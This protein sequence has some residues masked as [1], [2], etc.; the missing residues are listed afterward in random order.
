[1]TGVQTCALPIS[2]SSEIAIRYATQNLLAELPDKL[3]WVDGS[4]LSRFNLF[5]P[6]TIVKL[7][8]KIYSEVPRERLFTLLAKGGKSGTIKNWYKAEPIFIYG[9]T[10]TLSNNHCLSGFLITK[11][12]KTFIFSMMSNNFIASSTELRKQME[13]IFK[14]IYE[15]Y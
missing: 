9:K 10:G 5:T 13:K 12:G 4:G 1:V 15:K 11:S 8:E 2:L 14:M 3:Q 6:R 7:W